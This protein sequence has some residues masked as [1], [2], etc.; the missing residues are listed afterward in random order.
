[1]NRVH[2]KKRRHELRKKIPGFRSWKEMDDCVF[3]S[4]ERMELYRILAGDVY[5]ITTYHVSRDL[6]L[7]DTER[8]TILL[9][10]IEELMRTKRIFRYSHSLMTNKRVETIAKREGC[11]VD[12]LFRPPY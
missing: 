4:I 6:D 7:D 10:S 11:T 9:M 8:F 2:F 12:E 5:G 3:Q 1:M